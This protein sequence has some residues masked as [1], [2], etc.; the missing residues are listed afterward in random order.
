LKK[1]AARYYDS[2]GAAYSILIAYAASAIFAASMFEESR[3][4]YIAN[5]VVAVFVGYI[6]GYGV[7]LMLELSLPVIVLSVVATYLVL[8]APGDTS[9]S[10]LKQ[11]T[12]GLNKSSATP[13]EKK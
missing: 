3:R 7:D 11:L 13:G 1:V 6:V 2:L 10:E 12:R 8:L 9:V 4:R 5:S